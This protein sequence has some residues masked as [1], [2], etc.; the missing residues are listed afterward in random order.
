MHTWGQQ[1]WERR[2]IMKQNKGG[3]KSQR[4][5]Q[6]A[7]PKKNN[8]GQNQDVEVEQAQWDK[9]SK[10][11]L[12]DGYGKHSWRFRNGRLARPARKAKQAV[13]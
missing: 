8:E 9:C 12:D 6:G 7:S 11:L 3:V 2:H 10:S 5:D 1:K 13:T 4:S